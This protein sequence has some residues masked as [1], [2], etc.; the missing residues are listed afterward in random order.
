M[1]KEAFLH[2][3]IF[4]ISIFCLIMK[5]HSSQ[6][7]KEIYPFYDNTTAAFISLDNSDIRKYVY[8]SFDFSDKTRLKDIAYFKITTDSSLYHLNIQY[9]FVEKKIENL[10]DYDV[11]GKNVS[12]YYIKGA[13]FRKE[14]TEQGFDSY[15][16]VE[17]YFTKKK[18]L[19]FRIYVEKMKGDMIF[20]N[21][22]SMP[23]D[24]SL[25]N[26]NNYNKKNYGHHNHNENAHHNHHEYVINNEQ[27]Y[28]YNNSYYNKYHHYHKEWRYHSHDKIHEV[29]AYRNLYGIILLQIWILIMFL[30]CL[31]NRRKRNNPILVAVSGNM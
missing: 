1:S 31:V 8:F 11:L 13:N 6:I 28:F 9:S 10:V 4:Y 23:V 2:I 29:N 25:T 22:E 16:K 12:W 17:N 30:Y 5:T 27:R 20:E 18:T 14:K 3:M 7:I 24:N 21:L 19:L 26:N 15:I